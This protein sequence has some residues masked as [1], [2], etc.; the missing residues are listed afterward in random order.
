VHQ[1]L[2]HRGA[3]ARLEWRT[4]TMAIDID[5][6]T[7]SPFQAFEI[8]GGPNEDPLLPEGVRARS[9]P[10]R[11]RH[12]QSKPSG[13][14]R[15]VSPGRAAT[16]YDEPLGD[17]A[18]GSRLEGRANDHAHAMNTAWSGSRS[19]MVQTGTCTPATGCTSASAM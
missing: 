13:L 3:I 12:L 14:Q 16:V 2:D 9:A 1:N 15:R 4:R 5:A 6:A 19:H 10:Q 18:E 11:E 17:A 7:T 8:L